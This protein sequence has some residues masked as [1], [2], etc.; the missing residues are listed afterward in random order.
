M[1][2]NEHEAEAIREVFAETFA[3]G[4]LYLFGSRVDDSQKGGDIDLYV[5][6]D[7]KDALAEKKIDFLV[8]LKQRIG[9][10]KIDLVIDRGTHR[11]IDE[12]AKKTGVLLCQR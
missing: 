8:R 3:E 6:T 11:P 2:L 12:Q 1:R 7:R 5:V 10:Q 9:D 4:S